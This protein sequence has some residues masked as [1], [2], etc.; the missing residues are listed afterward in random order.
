MTDSAE[1]WQ[2]VPAEAAAGDPTAE[3]GIFDVKSGSDRSALDGTPY[4][5]W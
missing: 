2:A 1:T 4:A 3:P 5:E